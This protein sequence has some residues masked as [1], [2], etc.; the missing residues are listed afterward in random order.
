MVMAILEFFFFEK[1][2]IRKSSTIFGIFLL[3]NELAKNIMFK[4]K[5]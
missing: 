5:G 1:K 4:N 2:D 3:K